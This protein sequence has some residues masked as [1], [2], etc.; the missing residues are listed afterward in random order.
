M[1]YT[2]FVKLVWL[3]RQAQQDYFT[4]RTQSALIRAKD[5]EKQVDSI[6]LQILGDAIAFEQGTLFPGG[7]T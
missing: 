1:T 5:F 2:E 6:A 7:K 3:M 4:S